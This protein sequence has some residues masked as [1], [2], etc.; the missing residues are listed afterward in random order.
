MTKKSPK[1][2]RKSVIVAIVIIATIVVLC[3][4]FFKANTWQMR[5][6]SFTKTYTGTLPCADCSGL[7]TTLTLIQ[8][9]PQAQFGAYVLH[10]TYVGKSMQPNV[11]EGEWTITRGTPADPQAKVLNLTQLNSNDVAYYLMDAAGLHMLDQ[12]KNKVDS[13][14]NETLTPLKKENKDKKPA[15]SL[16]NP[17]SENCTKQ[18]GTLTIKTR[19]DGGEYGLCQFEG[20]QACEEW[21]LFRGECPVGGVKTT[22]FDTIEQ[23]YC[24]WVGGKTLAVPNAHCTLP[25]GKVCSD[26]SMYQGKCEQ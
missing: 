7:Q 21:A 14:F 11:S 24:A 12:K 16:A 3:T 20:N 25:S 6:P 8:Q 1:N 2:N 23:Q 22:G 17:A 10:E 15:N 26:D 9:K 5:H 19:G 4:L 18:G 13:P